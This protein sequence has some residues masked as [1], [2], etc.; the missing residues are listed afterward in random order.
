[1]R[2]PKIELDKIKLATATE[3][4]IDLFEKS[5]GENIILDTPEG[6]HIEVGKRNIGEARGDRQSTPTVLDELALSES[7]EYLKNAKDR[8]DAKSAVGYSDCKT[9]CRNALLSVLRTL[10]GVEDTREALRELYKQGILGVYIDCICFYR[11]DTS[12][13]DTSSTS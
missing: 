1:M 10:T 3:A 7:Y 13:L 5:K 4:A 6:Y 11:F 2:R 9:N 12:G 8:F